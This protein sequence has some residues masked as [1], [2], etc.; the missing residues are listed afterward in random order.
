LLRVDLVRLGIDEHVLTVVMHH[1]VTDGWSVGVLMSD[2]GELYRAELTGSSPE[3]VVLPVQ[4]VDFAVWQRQ[5]VISVREEQLGYWRCQLDGVVALELPTD[6][7][8]PAVRT[9]NGALLDFRV[10]KTVTARL[11]D[12]SSARG[13]TLFMTLVAA[14]QVLFARWSG[15]DDVAVGTVTSGRDRI[16]LEGLIGFFVNTVVLRS[17]VD[18]TQTFGEFLA[19]VKNIVL[20][21]FAHQDVPFEQLVDE[22][23]PARDISRTPLFQTMVVLQNTPNHAGALP[24]LDIE[25]VDLPTVHASFDIKVDFQELDGG[26]YG[27]L[28][29]NTDLFDTGK[30]ER[31]AAH[32]QVLLTGIASQPDRVV[33]ELPMLTE[34]ETQQ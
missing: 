26:L 19:Q 15:Q 18:R 20:E 11:K 13:A 10:S 31:L 8:R 12:L 1:I 6:R 27:A 3:L 7:P 30:V 25:D 21:A 17:Q 14:C 22:L 32:L 2:L 33:S 24:G 16:E 29:Y 34:A 23:Q 28:T 4:Y 5:R 9:I